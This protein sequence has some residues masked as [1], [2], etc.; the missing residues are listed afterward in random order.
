MDWLRVVW[1]FA[2]G[3]DKAAPQSPFA[4]LMPFIPLIA[5]ALFFY[6][7]VI[8][9]QRREQASR[10]TLLAGLKKN[11][12]VVTIGG[13]IGSV[14]NISA[15]GQEVTLKVDDNTRIKFLRTAI[16]KVVSAEGEAAKPAEST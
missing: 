9:N 6:F 3:E 1:L 4:D 5:I 7:F 13:V 10:E 8:R 14:A 15:D 11:D 2:A 12:K 16:Q